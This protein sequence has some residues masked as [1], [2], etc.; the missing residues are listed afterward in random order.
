MYHQNYKAQIQ[1]K[2]QFL[3][4]TETVICYQKFFFFWK[5]FSYCNFDEKLIDKI[6]SSGTVSGNQIRM[7]FASL[8]SAQFFHTEIRIFT[9]ES[10]SYWW[11]I[12]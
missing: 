7:H 2:S 6:F 10:F 11:N 3:F 12:L 4:K 5:Y 8:S 9:E 1:R